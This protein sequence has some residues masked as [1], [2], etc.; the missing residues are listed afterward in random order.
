MVEGSTRAGRKDE[1][2][3]TIEII[4]YV[5]SGNPKR[6]EANPGKHSVASCIAL[7]VVAHL[8]SFPVDLNRETPFETSKVSNITAAG[9]LTPE[10]QTIG[11]SAQL[12]PK[13]D[14]RQR[15]RSAQLPCAANVDVRCTNGA[16]LRPP[17]FD[18]STMLRMVPLPVPGRI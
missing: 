18:P 4:E 6:F 2:D 15:H 17:R 10:T 8:M 9:E 3:H 5:A 16:M 11:T 12:L 1:R 7:G 13:N 14:F